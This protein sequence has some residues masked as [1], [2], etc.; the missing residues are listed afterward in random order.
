MVY[1]NNDFNAYVNLV[2]DDYK[3]RKTN[4]FLLKFI[5]IFPVLVWRTLKDACVELLFLVFFWAVLVK[6]SQGRDLIVS[7]FEPDGLYGKMR[8][9][10]TTLAVISL[11]VSMWIIP[12]FMFHERELRTQDDTRPAYPLHN[13]LFFMHRILPL[14]PFW[15][16]AAVLFNGKGIIFV[17]ASITQLA[18]LHYYNKKVKSR[19]VRTRVMVAVG[20]LWLVLS[21]VFF[22]YFQEEY[23]KAKVLLSVNLYLLSILVFLIYYG[24][25]NR[26]LSEHATGVVK[27]ESLITKYRLNSILYFS[28]LVLHVILVTLIFFMPFRL[29][30]AP[31]SMMLYMFSFYVFL[32]DLVFYIVNVSK[33][34]QLVAALSGMVLVAVIVNSKWHLNT[35][36]YKMD[37]NTDSTIFVNHERD[38][39]NDRYAVL[40]NAIEENQSGKPYPIILVSGEGGGSRAGLWFS[41]NLINFD[42]DTKGKFRNHIFSVSTVSGSSVGLST[43]FTF[44]DKTRN[45]STIDTSW[46]GFPAAI[47]ANN[48]VGSSI[49]GLLLTDLY[50]SLGPG[51]WVKDR[52][53]TLQNE[54]AATTARAVLKVSGDEDWNKRDIPDSGM[55]LKKDFM[56]FFYEKN[57]N[58]LQYRKN[59]P[60][61]LINTCR[62]NDGRRG[63]FSSIKLD[64]IY[65]NE[66]I[67]IA[68]YMYE[69]SIRNCQ[70]V[71]EWA[72]K[73]KKVSMGQ[74]CNTSEL[75]PFFSA[76]AYIDSLGS[77]VDGGYHENSGLK[78]T[79]D[80]YMQLRKRLENDKLN[81][82]YMIYIM[83][84]KNGSGDKQLYKKMESEPV[85]LQPLHALFSQPFE[86]SASYFEEKA[87]V[88][89]FLDNNATFIPISLNP[90]I[91]VDSTKTSEIDPQKM[92]LESEM[93]QDLINNI[94][95]NGDG[96]KDTILN[97]PLARWLSKTIIKRIQM[98][99]AL[100][101]QSPE[102]SQLLQQ[103]KE[104]YNVPASKEKPFENIRVYPEL[105]KQGDLGPVD[106]NFVKRVRQSYYAN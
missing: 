72:C 14:V 29:S 10:F 50:K 68:G 78:S 57:G 34:R 17:L 23:T 77:F 54:E 61:T 43:V 3:F 90:K 66:A 69:D 44:W 87:R 59:T 47:Y 79:L 5:K 12:A 4:S 100:P 84:L 30:I 21:A 36:H 16:L 20:L 58:Q 85:L 80:I 38:E 76:P 63:I 45:A 96:K 75:F 8:I 22:A 82:K 89:S 42:W 15:L 26:I 24:A 7:L 31:E 86:G 104:I 60:I 70:G 6:M 105:K 81:G 99:A 64:G 74:A 53:T 33:R 25:D 55:T 49:R 2:Y 101:N 71:K 94:K 91:L 35:S 9:I 65:F 93:L 98:C 73:K 46:I 11:S 1:P 40:K 102:V 19:R 103:I 37:E 83:Y 95:E 41:Q 92:R 28:F 52:N 18:G 67:D 51:N 39:F 27:G 97:F 32:I 48:Y 13:H 106:S 62:S 56:Y 88:L